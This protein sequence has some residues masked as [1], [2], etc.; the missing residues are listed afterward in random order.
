MYMLN[1]MSDG[2]QLLVTSE[3]ACYIKLRLNRRASSPS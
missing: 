3:T 2:E 1:Y